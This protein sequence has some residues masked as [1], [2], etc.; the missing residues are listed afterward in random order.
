MGT[1]RVVR[2][3]KKIT[4]CVSNK[5]PFNPIE[6]TFV[7]ALGFKT[8]VW[9]LP[10]AAEMESVLNG[11]VMDYALNEVTD[12]E[13]NGIPHKEFAHHIKNTMKVSVGSTRRSKLAY[14]RRRMRSQ[15]LAHKHIKNRA[16]FV[17]Q[18]FVSACGV[19]TKIL[20]L[21]TAEMEFVLNGPVIDSAFNKE[22]EDESPDESDRILIERI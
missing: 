22:D 9:T 19:K 18:T 20:T 5:P 4:L 16:L 2:S 21:P 12:D 10:A 17:P 13:S 7:S 6:E 15:R 8:K 11:P 1:K 14:L 3:G